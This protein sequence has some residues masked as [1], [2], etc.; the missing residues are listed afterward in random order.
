MALSGTR[1]VMYG[2]SLHFL[3]C[4][5]VVQV[6]SQEVGKGHWSSEGSEEYSSPGGSSGGS[7]VAVATQSVYAAMG[8]D[9]GG[10][11]RNPARCALLVLSI[12]WHLTLC[13][14]CGVVGLKPTYGTLSRWGLISF[15]SSLDCPGS[16]TFCQ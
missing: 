8:S 16:T 12:A 15:G 5:M 7:A 4:L 10:S 1:G 14:F 6:D 11:V 13:S 3:T 9:T 2:R